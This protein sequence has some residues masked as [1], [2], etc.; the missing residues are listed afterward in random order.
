[1]SFRSLSSGRFMFRCIVLDAAE[2]SHQ[3]ASQDAANLFLSIAAIEEALCDIGI[4]AHIFQLS[5]QEADTIKIRTD[6]NVL[7]PGDFRDVINVVQYIVDGS[8]GQGML[9]FPS[10]HFLL[11]TF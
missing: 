4:A 9:R 3:I 6:T 11:Y 5:W 10:L 1:M 8:A 7:D 2:N